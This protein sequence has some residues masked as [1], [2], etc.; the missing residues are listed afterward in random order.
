MEKSR[1]QYISLDNLVEN[2]NKDT[3]PIGPKISLSEPRKID[4]LKSSYLKEKGINW[5]E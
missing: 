5:Q 2:L 4:P 1:L 3:S